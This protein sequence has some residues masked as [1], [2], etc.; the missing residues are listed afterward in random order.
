MKITASE[1]INRLP[2]PEHNDKHHLRAYIKLIDLLSEVQ[3]D[4]D[5]ESWNISVIKPVENPVI[6]TQYFNPD[7][8]EP[9]DYKDCVCNEP[10]M[11][12]ERPK[13]DGIVP[14]T[15]IPNLP[16]DA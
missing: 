11:F 7:N 10:N 16:P 1:F 2:I 4:S 15:L 5:T 13:G 3:Y 9:G 14:A 8:S 6:K 12:V